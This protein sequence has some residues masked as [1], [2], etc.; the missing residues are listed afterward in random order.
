MEP[1][2]GYQIL[3]GTHQGFILPRL[4]WLPVASLV[5]ASLLEVACSSTHEPGT[6]VGN[7]DVFDRDV[8]SVVAAN[9]QCD[10]S[11]VL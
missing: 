1:H 4:L 5:I 6:I 3:P 2:H 11:A 7:R 9:Q 10:S 8:S